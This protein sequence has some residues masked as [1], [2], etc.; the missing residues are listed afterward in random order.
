MY[1]NPTDFPEKYGKLVS[2]RGHHEIYRKTYDD[3]WQGK[4]TKYTAFNTKHRIADIQV[5]GSQTG[6]HFTV[7]YL[8]GREG[9]EIRAHELYHHLTTRHGMV[10]HSD[11]TQ[12]E[13][14]MK[15]RKNMSEKP[16]L[17]MKHTFAGKELPL[18]K[19]ADWK[20]NY[21]GDDA[22]GIGKPEWQSRFTI[23]RPRNWF[24]RK[25][26]QEAVVRNNARAKKLVDYM[27]NG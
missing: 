17:K 13:G 3:E 25:K 11:D 20:K 26:I 9:S 22:S 21:V 19:D 18:H 10:L 1:P 15:V 8:K 24:R 2:K 4:T 6:K 5:G 14:G 12:S 23:A 16:G 27:Q 7:S